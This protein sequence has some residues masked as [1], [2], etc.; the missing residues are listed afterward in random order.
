M[1]AALV[2]Q[3]LVTASVVGNAFVTQYYHILHLSPGH[4]HRFYQDISML[5]RQEEDGT[6]TITTT[7]EAI[8]AKILS[9]HNDKLKA[10]IKSVDSQESFSGGV[11][12]LVT[13][14]MRETDNSCYNFAQSF[15]LAPQDKGYFVLNDTFRYLDSVPAN[16]AV[17]ND[18]VVPASPELV[19]AVPATVVENHVP[20]NEDSAPPV[21]EAVAGEVYSPSE[22]NGVAI[23]VVAEVVDEAED[24]KQKIV[25]SSAKIEELPK[26]SYASI[27]M[28]L[29]G[30]VASSPP[31]Q[32]THRKAPPKIVEPVHP[33]SAPATD[34]PISGSEVVDNGNNPD[35]DGYSIYIKG[36]PMNATESLLEEVFKK[37]GTIKPDGIQVR[38]NRQQ[39]FCFGFV[40]FEDASSVQKALEASPVTIG[41][42]QAFVEEKRSTNNRGNSK[43]RFQPGRGSGGFRSEGVRGRG[44]YGG[45]R[46]YGRGDFNGRGGEFGGRGGRL[47]NRDGYQW[48]EN[49]S[50]NGGSRMN[51]AGGFPNGN[52]KTVAVAPQV[53]ATA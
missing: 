31:P 42:R 16:P 44:N 49:M 47:S 53:S 3:Q 38:S 15:F 46:G 6:M 35:A 19:Y 30:N 10:E 25:E 36:L 27:V 14:C 33:P 41:T 39:A 26:K 45:G 37:F 1:A 5:G 29:K 12:V 23:V 17:V 32:V 8:N 21:E 40:D 20:V 13:G 9:L 43:G 18:I 24:D 50:N 22:S 34:G 51:R 11:H 4:V 48:S 28:H 7:M 52:T 2:A